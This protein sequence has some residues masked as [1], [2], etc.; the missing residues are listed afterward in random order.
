MPATVPVATKEETWIA[1]GY[2]YRELRA[3]INFSGSLDI[4]TRS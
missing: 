3:V 2:V 4:S 1:T